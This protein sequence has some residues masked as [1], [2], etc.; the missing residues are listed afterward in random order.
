MQEI[1]K[2]EPKG[3]LLCEGYYIPPIW[4]LAVRRSTCCALV[5]ASI[6]DE[7]RQKVMKMCK[8]LMEMYDVGACVES[9]DKSRRNGKGGTQERDRAME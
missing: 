9:S 5:V 6:G 7:K 2:L 8:Q 1:T 3:L 4:V